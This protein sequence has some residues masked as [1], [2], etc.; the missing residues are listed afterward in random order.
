MTDRDKKNYRKI[1]TETETKKVVKV[2]L[3]WIPICALFQ[4]E[5][6]GRVKREKKIYE[7]VCPTLYPERETDGQ[8]ETK[9]KKDRDIGTET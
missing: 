5:R 3:G 4:R 1:E 2:G 8:T 7:C 9:T 6:K